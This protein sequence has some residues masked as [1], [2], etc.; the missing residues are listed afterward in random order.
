MP[1]PSPCWVL[2]APLGF[3]PVDNVSQCYSLVPPETIPFGDCMARLLPVACLLEPA[4]GD[5]A[6]T[7]E[8]IAWAMSWGEEAVVDAGVIVP[9]TVRTS[10]RVDG[11]R[12]VLA[13]EGFIDTLRVLPD[14]VTMVPMPT[15]VG[16]KA[17]LVGLG[18]DLGG[19]CSR[20]PPIE[21][22]MPRLE[23]KEDCTGQI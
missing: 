5:D 16:V 14:A 1:F 6:T 18:V 4:L 21:G 19:G 7:R 13:S 15:S 9:S 23:V 12:V 20:G 2:A 10:T 8:E 17:S 22:A 11:D 3:H